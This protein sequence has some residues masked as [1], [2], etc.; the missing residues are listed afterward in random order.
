MII[1]GFLLHKIHAR[2]HN[3]ESTKAVAVFVTH[4]YQQSKNTHQ[5][6][7]EVHAVS[8]QRL[9]KIKSDEIKSELGID[10]HPLYPTR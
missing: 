8:W 2:P 10:H 1:V 4:H 3:R 6:K 5:K 9:Q 7:V